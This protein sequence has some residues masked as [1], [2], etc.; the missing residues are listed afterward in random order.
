[1]VIILINYISQIII[2]T[3]KLKEMKNMNKFLTV[4]MATCIGMAALSAAHA[5]MCPSAEVFQTILIGHHGLGL[6]LTENQQ[7]TWKEAVTHAQP[8]DK[9]I[10]QIGIVKGG[11][12]GASPLEPHFSRTR[13]QYFPQ[14]KKLMCAYTE[15][16][17]G[18][19]FTYLLATPIEVGPT[20]PP[21]GQPKPPSS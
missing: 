11:W 21:A 12:E 13:E 9:P 14:S 5:Q 10:T 15:T 4:G 19:S 17:G 20:E 2:L 8:T 1:L 7:S 18:E 3:L 16:I 6:L